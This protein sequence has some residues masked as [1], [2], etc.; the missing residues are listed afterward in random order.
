MAAARSGCGTCRSVAGRWCWAGASACGAVGSRPAGVADL[1]RAGGRDPV[2]RAV[3]TDGP[4]RGLPAGRQGRPR[5]RPRSPATWGSAGRPSCGRWLI[6]AARCW[7]TPRGWTGR[8]RWGW[9][10]Q[11]SSRPP[12]GAHPVGHWPGRPGAGP[13]AGCGGRPHQGRRRRLAACSDPMT[14][15]PAS[16]RSPWTPGAATPARWSAPLGHAT[17]VVDHFHAIRLANTVV[18]QVRR[19]TQQATLGHRG[20]KPIRCIASASCC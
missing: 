6:T 18:D 5:G 8:L 15:W 10:R 3:L 4:G 13:S 12:A 14:G 16:A 1:D 19:R 11:A 2:P 17:V 9:T 7:M 20:R